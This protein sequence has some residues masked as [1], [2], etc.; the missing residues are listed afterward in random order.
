MYFTTRRKN[1]KRNTFFHS[2]VHLKT[3]ELEKKKKTTISHKVIDKFDYVKGENSTGKDQS[4]QSQKTTNEEKY[5]QLYQTELIPMLKKE[6]LIL[7]E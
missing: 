2:T 3:G 5:F 1:L 7:G 6:V 4:T